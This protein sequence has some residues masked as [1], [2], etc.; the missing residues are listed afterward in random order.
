[1]PGVI[2]SHTHLHICKPDDEALVRAAQEAG[3]TKLLTVGT[4]IETSKLALEATE[5]FPGVVWAAVGVHPND[6][7]GFGDAEA[8]ALRELAAHPGCLAIGETGFDY[9]RNGAPREDQV[10]AFLSQIALARETEKPL[11]IHTRDA[12]KD[13]LRI[14]GEHAQGVNVVLHCFSMPSRILECLEHPDWWISFAGNLTYPRNEDLRQAVLRVP[15]S[16]LLVETDAPYLT[17][18]PLRGKPNQP[19]NVVHTAQ[20]LALER[21]VPYS[22]LSQEIEASAAAVLRW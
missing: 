12:D 7:T 17:P 21:R 15:G 5:R 8:D 11:I 16:R 14:L 19:A 3:V 1:L 10:Q 22:E 13:T 6:A 20:A 18:V 4:G 9:Y 2:D